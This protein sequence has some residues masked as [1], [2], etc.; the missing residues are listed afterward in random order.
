MCWHC[1]YYKGREVVNV[2]ESLEKKEKK[3]REKEMEAEETAKQK[4]ASLEELSKK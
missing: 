1:G 3:Q 2:L 4:S